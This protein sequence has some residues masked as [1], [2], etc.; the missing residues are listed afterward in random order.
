MRACLELAAG[1][2]HRLLEES[3]PPILVPLPVPRRVQMANTRREIRRDLVQ[4]L[5]LTRD[6]HSVVYR[7]DL[8]DEPFVE[9]PVQYGKQRRWNISGEGREEWEDSEQL[10]AGYREGLLLELHCRQYVV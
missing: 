9:L 8:L 7:I 6:V 2:C 10:K 5:C 3:V 1:Q 4:L